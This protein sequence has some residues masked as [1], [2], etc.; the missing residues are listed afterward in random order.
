MISFISQPVN[1][2]PCVYKTF[3]K[4]IPKLLGSCVCF[5]SKLDAE[6]NGLALY[7]MSFCYI[8]IMPLFVVK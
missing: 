5:Q 1:I 8:P 3:D 7:D 4:A 2:S 6:E